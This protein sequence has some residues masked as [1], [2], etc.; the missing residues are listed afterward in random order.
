VRILVCGGRLYRDYETVSRYLIRYINPGDRDSLVI[1]GGATG[2]D[3]LADRWCHANG[4]HIAKVSPLWDVYNYAAGPIR[5]G[6][7]L[8]LQ[9]ELVIAFPGGKGTQ[10]MCEKADS[11]GVPVKRVTGE[12][13]V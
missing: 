2:A 5:N 1:T 13:H 10:D 11:A 9:P 3:Q 4:V 7:M 12:K 8:M 6:V